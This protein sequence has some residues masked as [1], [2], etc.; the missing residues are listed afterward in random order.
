[1]WQ[2]GEHV[3]LD[4]RLKKKKK[5]K[6]QAWGGTGGEKNKDFNRAKLKSNR[7]VGS[8]KNEG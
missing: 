8:G 4:K 3:Y 2:G 7:K 1:V 5:K 6:K